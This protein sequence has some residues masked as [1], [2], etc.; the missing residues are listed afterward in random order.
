MWLLLGTFSFIENTS[1]ALYMR[2]YFV[3][4]ASIFCP[5]LVS[6]FREVGCRGFKIRDEQHWEG[7]DA[8]ANP[9]RQ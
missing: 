6:Q 3:N 4:F 1:T 9:N 5:F 2:N 7:S 8:N